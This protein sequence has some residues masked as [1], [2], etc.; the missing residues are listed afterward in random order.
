M[1]KAS[2]ALFL[3]LSLA[4]QVAAIS[5]QFE[6][7]HLLT[8][9]VNT[10]R[11]FHAGNSDFDDDQRGARPYFSGPL[12][13]LFWLKLAPPTPHRNPQTVLASIPW[14]RLRPKTVLLI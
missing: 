11:G 4:T 7:D 10:G 3:T 9:L 8:T 5:V 6:N 12:T 13:A 14:L 1:M 2:L